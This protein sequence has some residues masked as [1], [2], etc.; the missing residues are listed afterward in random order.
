MLMKGSRSEEPNYLLDLKNPPYSSGNL[1]NI[2]RIISI[3]I[4]F[5]TKFNIS[6]KNTNFQIIDI[7]ELE[8]K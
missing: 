1:H 5:G 3:N 4:K 6:L 2:N 8:W 7:K